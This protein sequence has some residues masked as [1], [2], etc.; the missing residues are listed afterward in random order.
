MR[1]RG[2]L[3]NKAVKQ[4]NVDHQHDE[5]TDTGPLLHDGNGYMTAVAE[6]LAA[7]ATAM[8]TTT[9]TAAWAVDD[10]VGNMKIW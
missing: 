10:D 7:M 3:A 2:S 6:I 5:A 1:S 9:T 8:T 4:I